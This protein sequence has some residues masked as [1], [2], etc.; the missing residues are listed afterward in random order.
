MKE[1]KIIGDYMSLDEI[2]EY[3][4][5][6]DDSKVDDRISKGLLLLNAQEQF[7]N[8]GD[9]LQWVRKTTGEQDGAMTVDRLI[10][11]ARVSVGM[12]YTQNMTCSELHELLSRISDIAANDP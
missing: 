2:A 8:E 11:L 5:K 10:Q 6:L 9:F 1:V 12:I 7:E 3:L 4:P